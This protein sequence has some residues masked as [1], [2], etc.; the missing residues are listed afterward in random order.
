MIVFL[1]GRLYSRTDIH[2]V[3]GGQRQSGIS[4]PSDHP[5]IFIFSGENGKDFGY[6]DG[7]TTNE[8]YNYTGHGQ[9]GDMEFT[10]G[11]KAIWDHKKD[12]KKIYLFEIEKKGVRF[13]DEMICIGYHYIETK[14]A[15]NKMRKAIVFEL[16][17]L[18]ADSSNMAKKTRVEKETKPRK[19][20]MWQNQI[21]RLTGKK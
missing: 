6:K 8:I 17:P 14:D 19:P 9:Y 11:N 20:S 18:N 7:W 10:R 1:R 15:D 5:I 4:T 12:L 2:K 21:D 13:V 3:Y 16:E